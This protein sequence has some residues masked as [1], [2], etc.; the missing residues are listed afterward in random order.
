MN[1]PS[2]LSFYDLVCML[3]PGFVILWIVGFC[4]IDIQN[5]APIQWF[6]VIVL[7]YSVGLLYHRLLEFI[8]NKTHLSRCPNMLQ[9][10]WKKEYDENDN[11]KKNEE[12]IE[13]VYI[14]AYYFIGSHN[15]LYNLPILE[16]QVAFLRNSV[17]IIL[18]SIIKISCTL[19]NPCKICALLIVLLFFQLVR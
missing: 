15:S 10:A 8:A 19:E 11:N 12:K 1:V 14:R 7:S 13:D 9:L 2:Q 4:G 6:F 5:A 16:A 18:F 17:P 3:V